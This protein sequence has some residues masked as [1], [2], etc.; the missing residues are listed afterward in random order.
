MAILTS[1]YSGCTVR[2]IL[3]I[4]QKEH[5]A[6]KVTK[7]QIKKER[8]QKKVSSVIKQKG[9]KS[10]KLPTGKQLHHIKPVIEGGKTTKKNTRVVSTIKHKQIHKNRALNGKV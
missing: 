4:V 7:T 10:G 3:Y 6:K 5:M 2:R 8:S 1:I 9:Y